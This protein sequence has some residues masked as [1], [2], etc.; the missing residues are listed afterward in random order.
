MWKRE[1][2]QAVDR[3][4]IVSS[5]C[6]EARREISEVL[7]ALQ[8]DTEPSW[9]AWFSTIQRCVGIILQVQ[10]V[11]VPIQLVDLRM[12]IRVDHLIDALVKLRA[13]DR[14]GAVNALQGAMTE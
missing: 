6:G 11:S 12:K 13:R 5:P 14:D 4:N 10:R 9:D 2:S 8:T 3:E 7:H 1:K